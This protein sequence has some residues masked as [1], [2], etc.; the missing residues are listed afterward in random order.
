MANHNMIPPASEGSTR[1]NG[2]LYTCAAGSVISVLD[3][4]ADVLE[5]NGWLKVASTGA[6]ATAARPT[7]PRKGDSFHDSTLGYN[8]VWDGKEWRNPTSGA[9][10]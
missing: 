1:V 4:D 3:F 6:G 10:V 5:A 2:R 7:S 8:I 9:A